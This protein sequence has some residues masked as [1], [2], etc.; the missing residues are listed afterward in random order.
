MKHYLLTRFNLTFKEWKTSKNGELV[1]TDKWLKNRFV[2]FENYCLLSVKNQTNQDFV[3]CVFFDIKTPAQYRDKIE[4]ISKSYSNFKPIFIDGNENLKKSFIDYI[5]KDITKEDKYIITTRLDNDDLIHKDF[6]KTIQ[7]LYQP[8]DNM[9]ID[10]RKG[11]SITLGE[12]YS[13]IRVFTSRFNPFIS[14]VESVEEF[15]TVI[16]KMHQDWKTSTH[17][18]DYNKHNLWIEL[19]HQENKLNDTKN[20]LKRIYKIKNKDFGLIYKKKL[21]ENPL[22]IVVIFINSNLKAVLKLFRRIVNKLKNIKC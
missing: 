9:V 14:V 15:K 5:I 19:V 22:S 3:W 13:E 21:K 18:I 1:L 11:Y 10:L 12:P 2:L 7:Y 6:I 20:N 8:V 4:V 17:I 16:S